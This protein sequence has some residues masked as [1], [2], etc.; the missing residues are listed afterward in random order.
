MSPEHR[1]NGIRFQPSL[2]F[3]G[4][5]I[6]VGILLGGLFLGNIR[7]EV[8][9]LKRW[10]DIAEPEIHQNTADVSSLK[11]DRDMRRNHPPRPRQAADVDP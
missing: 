10:R 11:D 1:S 6:I 2:S 9:A 3:D 7:A 5:A 8:D 4:V